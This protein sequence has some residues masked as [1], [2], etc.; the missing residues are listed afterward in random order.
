MP[1]PSENLD[2]VENAQKSNIQLKRDI[3]FKDGLE[4]EGYYLRL[5]RKGDKFTAYGSAD[6]GSWQVIGQKSVPL[7][8]EL[9]VGLGADGNKVDNNIDNLNTAV[10]E[11][12]KLNK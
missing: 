9:Y 7:N 5:V 6:G 12:I 8:E 11:N 3:P 4:F 10:F 1:V 2:T